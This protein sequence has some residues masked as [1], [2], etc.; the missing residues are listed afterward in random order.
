ML[1]ASGVFRCPPAVIRNTGQFAITKRTKERIMRRLEHGSPGHDGSHALRG[2]CE[3]T[4]GDL[5]Q[6]QEPGSS[7][8]ASAA[9][10]TLFCIVV[11]PQPQQSKTRLVGPWGGA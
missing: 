8:S 11:L 6:Q 7:I 1:A 9:A 5:A 10:A 4:L 2:L 3:L